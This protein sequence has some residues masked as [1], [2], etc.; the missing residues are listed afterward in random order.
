MIS[1]ELRAGVIRLTLAH[2]GGLQDVAICAGIGH[3]DPTQN[4]AVLS[5]QL[6]PDLLRLLFGVKARQLHPEPRQ[7]RE[8]RFC[9]V[10]L[11]PLRIL[12]EKGLQRLGVSVAD[13]AS[14][15]VVRSLEAMLSLASA[16]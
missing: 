6:V 16:R 12:L 8:A 4:V 2:G 14:H 5:L 1:P 15:A 3:D 10:C 7:L 9:L 13:A 11:R